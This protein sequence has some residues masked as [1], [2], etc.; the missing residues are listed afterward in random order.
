[1]RIYTD[2]IANIVHEAGLT[3]MGREIER[4]EMRVTTPAERRAERER[5]RSI[6]LARVML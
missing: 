1:M 6:S 3:S 2:Y 5:R 4:G